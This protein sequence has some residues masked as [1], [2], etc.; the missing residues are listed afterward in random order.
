MEACGRARQEAQ[1]GGV[2]TP[3]VG[4]LLALVSQEAG[5][6][7]PG[8]F[9]EYEAVPKKI[10][11]IRQRMSPLRAEMKLL[12]ARYESGGAHQPSA[13]D[14]ARKNLLAELKEEERERYKQ[15]PDTYTNARGQ[16][17]ERE[18]TDGRAED[19]ARA[20]RRYRL[21]LDEAA[22]ERR[23]IVELGREIGTLLDKADAWK[24]TQEYLSKVLDQCRA[25]TYAVSNEM[26]LSP[27]Q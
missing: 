8:L 9:R 26:R 27:P 18:L 24:G 11:A 19:L 6:D 14:E 20:S 13:Y 1:G 22:L 21:F 2:S 5:Y 23:R 10:Y 3:D 17:I 16:E 15:S 4:R 12:Q 25:A 7:I